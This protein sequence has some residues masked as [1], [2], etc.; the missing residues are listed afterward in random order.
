MNF[1]QEEI[2]RIDRLLAKVDEEQEKNGNIL[3][4]FNDVAKRILSR[5]VS[6]LLENFTNRVN[7]IE[8]YIKYKLKNPI[9]ANKTI[10]KIID[11]IFIL[12][13]FPY[14]GSIYK[15]GPIRFIIYKKFLIFYEIKEKEKNVIIK[16][17][18]HMKKYK[19]F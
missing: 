9:I 19:N 4:S 18:I 5:I 8:Y 6:I 17:I 3:Y 2:K 12:E 7:Q 13:N 10:I 16:R 11:K 15:E 14:I 1:T